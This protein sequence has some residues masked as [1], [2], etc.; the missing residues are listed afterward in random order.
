MQRRQFLSRSL[1]ASTGA[2]LGAPFAPFV[3]AQG[4]L[5][6]LKF[7]LDFRVTSQTSPFFLA[8]AKGYYREEGLDVRIDVGAGSVASITRVASG[9]YDLGL[10]DL[11]SLAE[12]QS[13]N[14]AAPVQAIYQYYQRAPFVIIGR[15]DR[16]ISED[17]LSL[18]GKR[19]AAAAVESTRRCWPMVA[20]ALQTGPDL[21]EWVTT[22]FSA[23]D[24]VVVRGDVDAATYFH[25]SAVSLFARM[26]PK[27]LAVLD[28]GKAGLHL[29]GNA[30]LAGRLLQEKPEAA[31]AFVRASHRAL[32]EALANP[33]EALAA[34]KA[35][36]PILNLE[37]ERERWAIARQYLSPPDLPPG[38][39]GRVQP[40][41]LGRQLDEV[42]TVFQLAA[43]PAPERVFNPGFL[44]ASGAKGAA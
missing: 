23:R 39:L 40:A 17:F 12:F 2:A 21:F 10:G 36:E 9:A 33:E 24:N 7:T 26:P 44:P 28:Y 18:K 32:R 16:G 35:R 15:R 14:P 38:A 29:Y 20:R 13:Q 19:V 41:V 43:K 22:D 27:D 11:S 8:L 34:V 1:A 3:H 4:T 25:D 30:L 42:A 37:V 31:R 6:P 5:T